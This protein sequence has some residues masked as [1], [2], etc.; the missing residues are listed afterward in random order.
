MSIHKRMRRVKPDEKLRVVFGL[1]KEE[2]KYESVDFEGK[3]DRSGL[4]PETAKLLLEDAQELDTFRLNPNRISLAQ[5]GQVPQFE[6]A[7]AEKVLKGRPYFSM[8]ELQAATA[9]PRTILEDLFEVPPFGFQDKS[10]GREVGLTPI[11]GRYIIGPP[12]E[13]EEPVEKIGFREV[14]GETRGFNFRIVELVPG[15]FEAMKQ[16]PHDLKATLDGAVHPVLRDMEGFERFLVPGSLDVWFTPEV[17]KQRCLEIFKEL[18]LELTYA[19]P[20]VG[21]YQG[22][23]LTVHEAIELPWAALSAINRAQQFEEV[24]FAEPNQVGFEDFGP[25]ISD[26]AP[27]TE[28]EA[29]DRFW[30]QIAIDLAGAHTINPGSPD[31]TVF[32]IDSGCRTDHEELEPALR[33]DW[34]DLDLN[35]DLGVPESMM[36][37]HEESISHGT[38]VSGIVRQVAPGCR[39]LPV[40]ISG[41]SITPAY[42]L[43]AAAIRQ[44]LT[45]IEPGK[46]AVMNI[47]WRTNGD[48]IGI[49]E[50]LAEAQRKGVA[51]AASAGNYRSGDLQIPDKIHYPSDYM[52]R[53]PHLTNLCSVAAVSVGDRKAGYSYYGENSVTVAAPGGDQGGEGNGIHTTSTPEMHEFVAGTSF[54]AP[55]VAGLMALLFS[56]SSGLSAKQAIQI[57]KDSSDPVGNLNPGTPLGKRMENGTETVSLRINAR[58]ALEAAPDSATS[59]SGSVPAPGGYTIM[60]T[61]GP[62]GTISPAG[63]VT[64]QRGGTQTFTITP[65]PDFQIAEVLV[66]GNSVGGVTTYSFPNVT[67]P[68]TIAARFAAVP[69]GSGHYDP[70]GRLRINLATVEDLIGLPLIGPWLANRIVDFRETHGPYDNIFQLSRAGVSLRT[71][72]LLEPM[73]TV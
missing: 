71:I 19:V 45:Y 33:G 2:E 29:A 13:F 21:Y 62:N 17:P 34:R 38:K 69:A 18:G 14:F 68:H 43:R 27:K 9:L 70:S 64:V 66:D 37:P 53:Y 46:G 60:A 49:R 50:A 25:D 3:I 10:S 8:D 11:Y 40:K 58:A 36:T 5:I 1:S 24:V 22:K 72:L 54:A 52:R 35:F 41:Q 42:G 28:F 57:I 61:A 44:A 51:I 7:Q 65:A 12:G 39:V 26:T 73:I 67:T 31:V 23:L 59:P 56:K 55:H 48:I 6:I 4:P 63:T 15:D 16:A 47:S 32:I 20:G 30:N